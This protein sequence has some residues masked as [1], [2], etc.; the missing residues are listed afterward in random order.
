VRV[1]VT[2][3]RGF[4]QGEQ[5]FARDLMRAFLSELDDVTEFRTGAQWGVDTVAAELG[6]TLYPEALH[7]VFV[8]AAEHNVGVVEEVENAGRA[9]LVRA[10]SVV[11]LTPDASANRSKAYRARNEAML[12][13]AD[14]VVAFPSTKQEQNRS[15]TWMTVRIARKAGLGVAVVPLDGTKAWYEPQRATRA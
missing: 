13:G 5:E 2:G 6:L 15:G 7:V 14:L 11:R 4:R 10:T 1:A 12:D 3:S 9:G 8:P